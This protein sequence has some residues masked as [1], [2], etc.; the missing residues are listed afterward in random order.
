MFTKKK[1]TGLQSESSSVLSIF[2]RKFECSLKEKEI[3]V[4]TRK[5]S[6]FVRKFSDLSITYTITVA[7]WTSLD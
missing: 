1:K 7:G 6:I 2:V 3:K 4:F 5:L